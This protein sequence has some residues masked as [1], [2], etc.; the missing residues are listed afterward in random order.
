MATRLKNMI[1]SAAEKLKSVSVWAKTAFVLWLLGGA[2]A[3][4]AA[5]RFIYQHNFYIRWYSVSY[6]SPLWATYA[7]SLGLL[8]GAAL[9]AYL[10]L[11]FF[12]SRADGWKKLKVRAL[13]QLNAELLLAAAILT[14][15]LWVGEL[16]SV[17]FQSESLAGFFVFYGLES[18]TLGCALLFFPLALLFLGCLILLIRRRL[19][20]IWGDTSWICR[21][22]RRWQK[23]TPFEK[24]LRTK[25]LLSFTLMAGGILLGIVCFYLLST[26]YGANEL[27][28]LGLISEFLTFLAAAWALN[29][30]LYTDLGQLLG[31]IGAMAGGDLSVRTSLDARSDLYP[32]SCQLGEISESLQTILDKQMR[33][34]R[35]KIDL[36][37]NVSHD[38]KTPL[39]SMIGYVDL[40]KQEPLSDAA[41]DYVEVLS[42]RME[43]LKDMIQDIFDLSKSTSG[44]AEL[45]LET[46]DM[47]KLLEQTLGDMEDAIKSSGMV[48]REA[49]PEMP[50]KFTG[51]G[52]KMYRV[53]QNLIG[54]AL[55]YSLAGTRIYIIAERRASQVQVTIKNTAAYEMD[56][57][58]EEIMERFARGDKSRNTEG[59]G[60]GLAIAESFVKNMKG[61]LQVTV[62]GDQFKVQLTFP[63][64]EETRVIA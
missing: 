19:L 9:A 20:G 60:L 35:M 5:Y 10:Y 54:N 15:F 46:L 29:N 2:V 18:L 43:S 22:Y 1:K 37:T 55:K 27:I 25:Y 34:E 17:V 33:A 63:V 32:A 51:D 59:H 21:L 3:A 64:L 48:I 28:I 11:H 7:L 47:K 4:F 6:S 8:A 39:T 16:R 57:T 31:Q 14:G 58:S 61:G 26:W 12:R 44:T 53:L 24:Q 56:F 41:Q 30:R 23:S 38:L 62:D 49:M 42:S 45:H 52:K 50:L 36:I 13:D 40:L